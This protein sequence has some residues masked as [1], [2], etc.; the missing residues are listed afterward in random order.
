M[1]IMIE[2]GFL[3]GTTSPIDVISPFHQFDPCFDETDDFVDAAQEWW[4]VLC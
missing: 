2:L 3:T 4:L 1:S